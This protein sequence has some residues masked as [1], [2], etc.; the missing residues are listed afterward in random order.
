MHADLA[1]REPRYNCGFAYHYLI[2]CY[3]LGSN[4]YSFTLP[5]VKL[6]IEALSASLLVVIQDTFIGRF[7]KQVKGADL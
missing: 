6:F 1:N 3:Q 2:V 4:Y 5:K 7:I